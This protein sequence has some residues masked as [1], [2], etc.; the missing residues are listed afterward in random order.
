[1]NKNYVI[2]LILLLSA[3][4]INSEQTI[5][6]NGTTWSAQSDEFCLEEYVF[7][8]EMKLKAYDCVLEAYRSGKYKVNMDT[9]IL[10]I[11]HIDD[12]PS[13]AGGNGELKKRFQYKL[14]IKTNVLEQFYFRDYAHDSE[15]T[16][17][18]TPFK[19]VKN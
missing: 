5:I 16:I 12:T 14:L 13:F 9:L 10:D 2:I 15:L 18:N 6:L 17:D 4:S 11:Y 1:M 7:L 8:P 19:K 3:C